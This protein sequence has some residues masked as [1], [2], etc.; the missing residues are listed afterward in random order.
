MSN[1]TGESL[2]NSKM[3]KLP[4]QG[5]GATFRGRLLVGSGLPGMNIP[6][7]LSHVKS[8]FSN[9]R[10]IVIWPHSRVAI[11]GLDLVRLHPLM[12]H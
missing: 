10:S 6:V 8:H 4:N 11:V 2:N 12:Q 7:Q 9:K 5:E 1:G 3:E